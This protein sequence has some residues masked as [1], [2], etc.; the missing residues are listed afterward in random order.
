MAWGIASIPSERF[1]AN[2]RPSGWCTDEISVPFAYGPTVLWLLGPT[3][4]VTAR[5]AF[6]IWTK[7][8]TLAVALVAHRARL[9]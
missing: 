2:E 8:G 1:A 4:V 6:A 5:V 9:R 3:C 7:A